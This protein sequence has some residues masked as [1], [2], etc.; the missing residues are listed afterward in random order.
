MTIFGSSRP[1]EG[2]EAYRIAYRVGAIAARFGLDIV[3]GG[4]SGTMEASARGAVD[5]GGTAIGVTVRTF[6]YA[7]PNAYLTRQIEAPDLFR[8]LR[9]LIDLGDLYVVL[10]G[11]TGT[12][13]ELGLVWEFLNKGRSNRMILVDSTWYG[14]VA[15]MPPGTRCGRPDPPPPDWKEGADEKMWFCDDV[16]LSLER[17]LVKITG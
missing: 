8:R 7:T 6:D 13:V 3:N 11:G 4:Y 12:L 1:R 16:P 10:P 14:L 17:Y 9:A 15:M 5:A 2:N